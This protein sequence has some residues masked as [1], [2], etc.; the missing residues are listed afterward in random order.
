MEPNMDLLGENNSDFFLLFINSTL[1]TNLIKS[2]LSIPPLYENQSDIDGFW[3]KKSD[4][5][6]HTV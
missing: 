6:F 2:N 5:M 3:I 4:Y 1:Q